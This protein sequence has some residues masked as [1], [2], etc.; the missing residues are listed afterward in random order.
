MN[1]YTCRNLL[2]RI[3]ETAEWIFFLFLV[4]LCF[5]FLHLSHHVHTLSIFIFFIFICVPL[6]PFGPIPPTHSFSHHPVIK[7]DALA[8]V[9][10]DPQSLSMPGSSGAGAGSGSE[11]ES[12]GKAQPKRLH[13]SNIPFRFRDPDLRQMFGVGHS[14]QF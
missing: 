7:E 8:P 1:L 9:T 5:I 2:K 12:S 4:M 6:C 13:V 3:A 14:S 11:E 10:S